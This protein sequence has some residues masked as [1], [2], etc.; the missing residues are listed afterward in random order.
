MS[1]STP[2][3]FG[4]IWQYAVQPCISS[5]TF[6]SVMLRL[7]GFFTLTPFTTEL[8]FLPVTDSPV[9]GLVKCQ[10]IGVPLPTPL[11]LIL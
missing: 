9:A 2:P 8:S 5:G 10:V 4:P 1:E 6:L 11:A 3:L 7:L